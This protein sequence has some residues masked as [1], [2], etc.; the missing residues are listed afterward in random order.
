MMSTTAL[1]GMSE[2]RPHRRRSLQRH[3]LRRHGGHSFQGIGMC[4]FGEPNDDEDLVEVVEVVVEAAG[5]DVLWLESCRWVLTAAD[6]SFF[7]VFI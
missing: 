1:K 7:G 2:S 5:V 6:E 3:H 4:R